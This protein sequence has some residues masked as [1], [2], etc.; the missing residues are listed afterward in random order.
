MNIVSIALMLAFSL[1]GDKVPPKGSGPENIPCRISVKGGD[2]L[3]L[4]ELPEIK[5]FAKESDAR[6]YS[7]YV[8]RQTRLEY[9]VR[10]VYPYARIAAK[11]IEKVEQKIAS[12]PK[13][14]DQKEYINQ[15]YRQ[16]FKKFKK[17]LMSLT[18][19]QGK[20]LVRL[21][22]RETDKNAFNQI[23]NLKGGFNA[24]FWQSIALLFGNNLRAEYD[25]EGR[26]YRIEQIVLQIEKENR[27]AG[28]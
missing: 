8:K 22:D 27:A 23:K 16:L 17:P 2:T 24:T 13:N 26:D 3:Y 6:K 21:I 28:R 25:P 10:K 1:S 4:A 18:V 15:E 7:R 20:I 12:L 19:N 14:R 5:I 9:Y 11:E